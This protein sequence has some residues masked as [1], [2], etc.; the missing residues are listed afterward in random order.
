M[1]QNNEFCVFTHELVL[2]GESGYHGSGYLNL[3]FLTSYGSPGSIE[4]Q[5]EGIAIGGAG[6]GRGITWIGRG[7][8]GGRTKIWWGWGDMFIIKI[9]YYSIEYSKHLCIVKKKCCT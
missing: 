8:V 5:V 2:G 3:Y 7:W 1:E 4:C 6:F 9:I